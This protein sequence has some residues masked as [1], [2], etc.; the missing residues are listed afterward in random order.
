MSGQYDM[1]DCE[2]FG[3]QSLYFHKPLDIETLLEILRTNH[4][5]PETTHS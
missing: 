1:V 5:S 4:S 2:R 3:E